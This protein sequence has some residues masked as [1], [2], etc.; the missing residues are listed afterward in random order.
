[1]PAKN[2][3]I[4]FEIVDDKVIARCDWNKTAPPDPSTFGRMLGLLTSGALNSVIEDSVVEKGTKDKND[5]TSISILEQFQNSLNDIEDYIK[6]FKEAHR[7]KKRKVIIYEFLDIEKE[8]NYDDD[9]D[10][11]EEEQ[12]MSELFQVNGFPGMM[13]KAQWEKM[14][15]VL[16]KNMV[17]FPD[18]E[19]RIGFTNFT[20]NDQLMNEIRM[21]EGVEFAYL[22]GRYTFVISI[23]KLFKFTEVA[24][25][26][27]KVVKENA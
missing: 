26:I 24:K 21:A 15:E 7:N 27:R 20:L 4:T 18:R 19:T 14:I 6:A 2:S 5:Q 3:K 13:T 1:M 12:E 9:I 16:K 11:D 22:V 25:N 8:L 17:K 10:E 23:G